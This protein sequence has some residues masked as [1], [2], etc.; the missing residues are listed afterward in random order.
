MTT[1]NN[2]KTGT[3]LIGGFLLVAAL[4]IVVAVTGYVNLNSVNDGMTSLFKDETVPIEQLGAVDAQLFK[5]RGDVFK[6]ALMVDE[7]AATEKELQA[8][9]AEVNKQY[10]LYKTS[11]TDA[12]ERDLQAKFDSTWADYQKAAANSIALVQAGKEAE[13]LKTFQTGG[14]TSN[15]RKAVDAAI[16]ALVTL[17][18]ENAS[19]INTQ[20]GVTASRASLTLLIISIAGIV[21][22]VGLGLI[23]SA[24]ITR[25]LAIVVASAQALSVG[26]MQRSLSDKEKDKVR[27]RKDEIGDI[28]QAFDRL[29]NY[30]QGMGAA[31]Q[32][33]AQGDL[34]VEVATQG[35]KDELGLA[36]VQM[37]SGLRDS[38]GQ[39]KESA[40]NVAA[41]S[42]Q[43]AAA[44]SQAGS[45]TSQQTDATTK[46]A[47]SVEEM[48]RAIDGVAKG[49]QEQ[50]AAVG[51]A[52]AVTTQISA[53]IQGVA[54]N[55][56]AVTRDAHS[57][58]EAAKEGTKTV[59]ATIRGME[60]IKAKVG[61]SAAKVQEMGQRSTEIGAIVE[62]IE[63]IASQTNLLALNAAIEAAR[64]GEHGKGFAVVADEVR[65][66]AERAGAATKEIGVLIRGIQGTVS[67]AV[68]AMGEG[69]REV[70]TGVARANEAGQ[71]LV[72]I[73]TAAQ[74]VQVQAEAAFAAT[75]QMGGLSNDLIAATDSVSAVVEE[76]TASTEEMAAGS[77]EVTTAIE[78]VASVSEELS[79]QVEE[80]AA[81]ASSLS[82][83]SRTLQEVVARFK[84][85]DAA[86]ATPVAA[87]AAPKRVTKRL[88]RRTAD[89]AVT[90]V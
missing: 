75:Q 30:M 5:M 47:G 85:D 22:A 28:G 41:A 19:K 59:N 38:V 36:F 73:L 62:T 84:L 69:A 43:L 57:A 80:V 25:P 4:L 78:N 45:A 13:A 46:T 76:N 87:L 51:R 24:S 81:S 37:V 6:Y 3:K 72:T 79:A 66:L 74:A 71:V 18:V 12:V 8:A 7:R 10:Q 82:D 11:S 1:F 42:E 55:A 21:I 9:I 2:L 67:E 53:A 35:D 77:S 26:D 34:T 27:L 32:Q 70:E 31:A 88:S 60:S 64:A 29:I 17:N 15:A 14:A 89:V 58:A 68:A 86:E 33:I 63:D 49:A 65:K 23:I 50:A 54:G 39:V 40:V 52:S 56:Q 16:Q 61:V 20:G 90:T 48:K 44:A 83:L